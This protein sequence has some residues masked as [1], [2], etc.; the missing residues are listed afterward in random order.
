[1]V[2]LLTA[3][4][5]SPAASP[6]L[7]AGIPA[8][9]TEEVATLAANPDDLFQYI[10][11]WD[12]KK[13]AP[14]E[15]QAAGDQMSVFF[16]AFVQ[17]KV[18]HLQPAIDT[19]LVHYPDDP[20][21]WD[22]KLCR[23]WFL[24]MAENI[25]AQEYTDTYRQIVAAPEASHRA[26]QRAR[27]MLLW[28][29]LSHPDVTPADFTRSDQEMAAFEKDFP[30][31]DRGTE[32]VAERMERLGAVAPDRIVP[33]LQG[34]V[35][36]PNAA[37]AHAAQDQLSLR[38]QPLDLQFTSLDG[39]PVD[40]AKL[41]GKV[42][43]LDFWTTWCVPCMAKVPEALALHRKYADQGF[44]LLGISLDEDQDAAR[45]VVADRGM[46]WPQDCEGKGWKSVIAQRLG[47]H[48]IPNLWLVDKKGMAHPLDAEKDDLDARVTALLAE[49]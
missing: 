21:R 37:T 24:N 28:Q 23:L 46:S 25:P 4:E 11:D 43:L 47:V 29:T 42:V 20:R 49:P 14:A 17:E 5:P 33:V 3:A 2:G 44:Q 36:S 9:I 30:E 38:T 32:L 35:A 10:K 15:L 34:L 40:L 45:K 1:M 8:A 39:T 16:R 41:R 6:T 12:G 22:V 13:A 7:A 19:F 26:K 27:Y 18:V 31:D 48:E